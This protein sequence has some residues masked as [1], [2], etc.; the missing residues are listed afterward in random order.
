MPSNLPN[1]SW[2]SLLCLG[3]WLFVD[4]LYLFPFSCGFFCHHVYL[5]ISTWYCKHVSN[6]TPTDFPKWNSFLFRECDFF[7][8]PRICLAVLFPNLTCHIFGTTCYHFCHESNIAAPSYVSYPVLVLSNFSLL[9]WSL[10][11]FIL[12][13]PYDNFVII[14][15]R[16]NSFGWRLEFACRWFIVWLT[17]A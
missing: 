17:R 4:D 11:I 1:C 9:F 15:S 6:L 12:E 16:H 10:T 13:L 2:V 3:C 5:V 7:G 14:T 8:S